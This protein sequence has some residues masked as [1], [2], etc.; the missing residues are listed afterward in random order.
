MQEQDVV[1][2]NNSAP[3]FQVQ[4]NKGEISL[5]DYKGKYVV[6]YFYPKDN[7]PGC[8]TEAQNFRDLY[9]KF[10][11]HNA[12]ILG[13]SRDTLESHNK[14]ECKYNLPFPLIA[15]RDSKLCNMFGVI[16]NKSIFGKTALGLI[17][18]TFLI[19]PN[20]KLIKEW[21]NV[22]VLDHAQQV[23]DAIISDASKS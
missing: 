17:R 4:S 20:G 12:E 3:D 23:L 16:K 11:E 9:P 19:N 21:R 6:I 14:F 7:T 8:S 5:Q 22:K 13:V 18:S 1:A 15:D 2:I 10:I